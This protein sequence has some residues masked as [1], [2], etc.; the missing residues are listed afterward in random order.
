MYI[1]SSV[2]IK[3]LVDCRYSERQREPNELSCSK[4]AKHLRGKNDAG[5]C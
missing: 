2:M 3:L 4:R 1:W 5:F